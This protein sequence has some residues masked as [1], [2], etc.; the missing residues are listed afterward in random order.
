MFN[1]L[2]SSEGSE[3][4]QLTTK[5]KHNTYMSEVSEVATAPEK[6]KIELPAIPDIP[7][8]RNEVTLNYVIQPETKG[9]K[10]AEILPFFMCFD[11]DNLPSLDNLV[12]WINNDG[13]VQKKIASSIKKLSKDEFGEVYKSAVGTD[14]LFDVDKFTNLFTAAMTEMRFYAEKLKELRARKDAL[15]LQAT[16]LASSGKPEA[17]A[18][19]TEILA[20]VAILTKDIEAKSRKGATADDEDDE[21]TTE[22][23]QS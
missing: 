5:T 13:W 20:Q 17:F 23:A 11:L 18:G 19:V 7:I 10:T 4:K 16:E 2:G 14:G 3:N 6:P 21:Q 15:I 22:G 12:K 1:L 8:T 9:K